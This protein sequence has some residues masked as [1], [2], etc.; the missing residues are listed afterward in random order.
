MNLNST[1]LKGQVEFSVFQ[2]RPPVSYCKQPLQIG[3]ILNSGFV[4][5]LKQTPLK[6]LKFRIKVRVHIL[7]ALK[8]LK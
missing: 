1:H 3:E 7:A 8:F 5:V 4:T 6:L 2:Y